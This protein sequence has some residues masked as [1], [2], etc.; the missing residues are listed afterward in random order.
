MSERTEEVRETEKLWNAEDAGEQ[1][2]ERD[3]QLMQRAERSAVVERR[4]FRQKYRRN[5]VT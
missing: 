2:A 5:A 1:N 4:Y 3:K